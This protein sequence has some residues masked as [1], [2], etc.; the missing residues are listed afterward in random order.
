MYCKLQ[1]DVCTH[2]ID[3]LNIKV[4]HYATTLNFLNFHLKGFICK[5]NFFRVIN[6]C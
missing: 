2:L 5:Y 6:V 4:S 3:D 1:N